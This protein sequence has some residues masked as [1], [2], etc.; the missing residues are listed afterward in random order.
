MNVEAVL[1]DFGGTLFDYHP[2]NAQVWVDILQKLGFSVQIN[3][4]RLQNGLA[5]QRRQEELLASQG[6]NDLQ[7]IDWDDPFDPII[8]DWNK[9]VS[10]NFNLGDVHKIVWDEFKKREGK[11]Q[12]IKE[13]KQI[14]ED[15]SKLSIKIGM[16]S[17]TSSTEV[18]LRRPFLEKHGILNY[19]DP[20]LFSSELA[21]SKPDPRIFQ[22]AINKLNINPEQILHVGDSIY[23]DV[24][25]AN[26]VGIK[27]VLYDPLNLSSYKGYKIKNLMEIIDIIKL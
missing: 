10:K 17:N 16:I 27:P 15:L 2:S 3:D 14:L 1:F 5:D 11:Y 8:V 25:G 26:K 9:I 21:L 12:I 6:K 7:N 13:T 18:L 19:F 24:M 4:P 23:A 22:L 20:I